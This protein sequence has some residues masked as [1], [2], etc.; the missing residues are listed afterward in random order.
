M[1]VAESPN[2][3]QALADK[4]AWLGITRFVCV[5]AFSSIGKYQS[6]PLVNRRSIA[7]FVVPNLEWHLGP[8]I[9]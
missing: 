9:L 8:S 4:L 2:T 6:S 3:G 1:D 5:A 7:G